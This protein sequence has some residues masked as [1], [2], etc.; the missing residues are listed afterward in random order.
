MKE[1]QRGRGEKGEVGRL[2][3][4]GPAKWREE[5]G[6]KHFSGFWEI[7]SDANSN[8]ERRKFKCQKSNEIQVKQTR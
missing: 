7:K 3:R 1:A 8:L 5:K 2:R 6:F 4:I